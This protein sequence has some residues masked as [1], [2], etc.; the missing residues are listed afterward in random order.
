MMSSPIRE[1]LRRETRGGHDG[2]DQAF[3]RLLAQP[4]GARLFLLAQ[5]DAVLGALYV[6]EGATLGARMLLRRLSQAG[7]AMDPALA[8]FL[9]HNQD[10][11][12]W[13]SFVALLERLGR[14]AA[15]EALLAGAT[16]AFALFRLSAITVLDGMS[17]DHEFPRSPT[18]HDGFD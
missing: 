8:A 11:A 7:G 18:R 13:R 14:D 10:P 4:R 5:G 2:V 3:E 12:Q 6:L 16:A 1:L 17:G 15:P 9:G